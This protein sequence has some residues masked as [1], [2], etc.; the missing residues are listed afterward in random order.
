MRSG[1]NTKLSILRRYHNYLILNIVRE[2]RILTVH[3]QRN[4][5]IQINLL[6]YIHF[7]M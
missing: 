4:K 7:I 3:E 6:K 1:E 2:K 5:I